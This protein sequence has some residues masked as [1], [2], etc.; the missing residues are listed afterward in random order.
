MTLTFHCPNCNAPLDYDGGQNFIVKCSHCNSSVVV[1]EDLRPA[2][3]E[4]I[5]LPVNLPDTPQ[6]PAVF[7]TDSPA[8]AKL[9]FSFGGPGIGPGW[10]NDA[11][12]IAVDGAG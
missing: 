9:V 8:L 3:P 1:P 11:R 7:R 5:N 2:K 6:V 12:S 4:P 10:F